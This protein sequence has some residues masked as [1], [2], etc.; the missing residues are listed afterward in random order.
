MKR[1]L[2]FLILS[3]LIFELT[4]KEINEKYETKKPGYHFC[5]VDYLKNKFQIQKSSNSIIRNINLK[6][7]KLKTE[8][9]PIRIFVD[10]TYLEQQAKNIEGMEDKLPEIKLALNKSVEG[11]GKLLEVVSFQDNVYTKLNFDCPHHP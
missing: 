8:Y 7:R 9:E 10:T 1:F 5:G 3:L 2:F 6:T 11:I 4:S